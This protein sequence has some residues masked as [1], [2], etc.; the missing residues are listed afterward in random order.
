MPPSLRAYLGAALL[1]LLCIA[2][3]LT[4]GAASAD[5]MKSLFIG[6]SFFRP[7]A[8]GMAFHAAEAGIVGHTQSVVFAGG[9]NGAPM[10][11]WQ[12]M[13]KRDAITEILDGGD[14]ELFG[15]TYHPD[16]P[17][18]EGYE[19]WIDYALAQNPNT[20]IFLALPW[21]FNPE[22]STAS[23][24]H[25]EWVTGHATSWHDLI[26]YLRSLY[27]GVEITCI[28]YGQSAG[29]LRLL[30]AAN[31]LP[32][33]DFEVSTSGEAIY[34]DTFG[35]A[36]EILEELGQLV[37]LNAIYDVDLSSYAYDPGYITDLH[38]IA[39]AIMDVHDDEFGEPEPSG[40]PDTP[41][42][43]CRAALKSQLIYRNDGDDR[44]DRLTYKWLRGLATSQAEFGNPLTTTQYDLCIYSG[45]ANNLFVDVNVPAS[46]SKWNLLTTK[47]YKFRD[48]SG[49]GG[50]TERILLKGNSSQNSS[51]ILWKGAGADL[52]DI[53][54]SVLP[55]PAGGFPLLVQVSGSNSAACF[56][57]NFVSSDVVSNGSDGLKIKQK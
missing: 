14:I 28:P 50:G 32:D 38:A 44:R 53:P 37:W 12:D 55:I 2:H 16:H 18:S 45:N 15:M 54:P 29:E 9:A 51:K 17:T 25:N 23:T 39:Q 20:R 41:K 24:Y 21:A 49:A 27:P 34:R 40:C 35:H 36:D 30:F 31:N 52:P 1:A 4:A 43:G 10:A 56:E 5:G 8:E 6:H 42:S 47:G 57:T 26:D 19:N 13:D 46:A 22:S 48:A 33:V 11:L 3:P 7:F